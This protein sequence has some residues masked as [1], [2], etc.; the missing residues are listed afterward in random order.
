MGLHGDTFWEVVLKFVDIFSFLA[1]IG[2][3]RPA[4]NMETCIR[5]YA[6]VTGWGIL[7]WQVS[8]FREFAWGILRV[9]TLPAHAKSWSADNADIT[10]FI[11]KGERSNSST[12]H[13]LPT[14]YNVRFFCTKAAQLLSHIQCFLIAPDIPFL[15]LLFSSY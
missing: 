10:D 4:L 2:Q 5:F 11:F 8:T 12:F 6:R 14:S 3:E 1:K 7:D 15:H 9:V 13:D